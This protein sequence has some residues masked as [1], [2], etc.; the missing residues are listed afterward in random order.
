M[1]HHVLYLILVAEQWQGNWAASKL[2]SEQDRFYSWQTSCKT[3]LR[4][5]FARHSETRT[6]SDFFQ[7]GF[8]FQGWSMG[9]MA[10]FRKNRTCIASFKMVLP[11]S[12]GITESW[13][14]HWSSGGKIT[15]WFAYIWM[16]YHTDIHIYIYHEVLSSLILLSNYRGWKIYHNFSKIPYGSLPPFMYAKYAMVCQLFASFWVALG[17]SVGKHNNSTY[18][19]SM[20]SRPSSP[21]CFLRREVGCCGNASCSVRCHFHRCGGQ[22]S[23][24]GLAGT[25]PLTKSRCLSPTWI[26]QPLCWPFPSSSRNESFPLSPDK[27]PNKY[28]TRLDY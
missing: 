17:A 7:L 27:K 16:I 15:Q 25:N 12:G 4:P 21:W 10:A 26:H 28:A 5:E 1:Q 8:L 6:I 9:S 19:W 20:V 18:G 11:R 22:G 14:Q 13:S 23:T 2:L 3:N 24:E